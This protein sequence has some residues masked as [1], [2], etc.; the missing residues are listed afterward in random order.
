MYDV[1][2]GDV[3]DRLKVKMHE[4]GWQGE[5]GGAG[6]G[7]EH[8]VYFEETVKDWSTLDGETLC[9]QHQMSTRLT[10]N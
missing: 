3:V 2:V 7:L 9:E 1:E 10:R 5:N 4:E 6:G 8:A